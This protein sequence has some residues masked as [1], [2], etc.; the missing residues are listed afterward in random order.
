MRGRWAGLAGLAAALALLGAGCGGTTDTSSSGGGG[1][2][3]GAAVTPASA[4]VYVTVDTD[5]SSDQWKA[6][7]ALLSRFPGRANLLRSIQSSLTKSGVSWETDVKPALGKE[8]DLAVLDFKPAGN[9]VGLLQ[10]AD[11]AKFAALVAKAEANDP[12]TRVVYEKVGDWTVVADSQAKIDLYKD[13]VNGAKLAD[14]AKFQDAIGKLSDSAIVKAYANG[15]K[16]TTALEK[17]F[18]SSGGLSSIAQNGKLTSGAAELVAESNGVK[19][20]GT[21]KTEGVTQTFKPYKAALLDRVPAGALLYL[22]FNGEGIATEANF[23]KAFEEGFLGTGAGAVPGLKELLPKLEKLGPVFAHETALYVR[24]GAIIPEIT[25]IGQPDN[26]AEAT[27]A[28]DGLVAELRALGGGKALTPKPLT[29]GDVHAK[30]LDFGQFSIFYGVQ[31]GKL[32]VTDMEQA[33]QDLKGAGQK[34]SDDATFKEAVDAA[35]MPDQN[36]GFLYVNLK[37]SVSLVEGLMR[38]GGSGISPDVVA[39]LR[40]LRTFLVWGAFGQTESSFTAFLG[41]Q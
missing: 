24:P 34:L 37:D 2:S 6:A 12:T 35:G 26:P 30:E 9:V 36:S 17:A 32:I 15:A 22:T 5:V 11:D 41:I 39:N 18:P 14:D 1:V 20:H 8:L 19:L 38:L 27:A 25:L 21:F 33:F 40:P 4:P 7:D 29:I 16:V 13:Q 10:P 31:D 28:I 3:S 23:R